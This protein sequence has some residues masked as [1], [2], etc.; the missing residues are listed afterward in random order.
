MD[1]LTLRKLPDPILRKKTASVAKV[2]DSVR[3]ILVEMARIMYLHNGVGLA[4]NQVGINKQLIVID[5]GDCL[6]KMVNPVIVKRTG[7][8]TREE[9]CL[10]CPNVLV[11]VKR[12]KKVICNYLDDKGEMR[13]LLAED[14]LARAIQHETDHL[15]GKVILDYLS[16]LKKIFMKKVH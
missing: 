1:N 2:T 10:S 6:M 12:A 15:A 11:K 4:A 5:I 9:G 3:D 14:L 7:S 16:P 13:V 8:E